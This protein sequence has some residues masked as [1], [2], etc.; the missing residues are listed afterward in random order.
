M[1]KLIEIPLYRIAHCRAGDKGDR[2][3]ISVI[4][5]RPEFYT[6]LV[7]QVTIESVRLH[8]SFRNPGKIT[9]YLLPNIHAMNLVI[10]EVLDG[11]VNQALNLD[12]HGKALSYWLLD[13]NVSAPAEWKP[14]LAGPVEE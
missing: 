9:R 8:F 12:S 6:V 7:N 5:W 1:N 11:G 13:M 3:N 2:S 10:D 4:A 14:L